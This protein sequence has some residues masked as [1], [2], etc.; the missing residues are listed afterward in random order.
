[1]LV[2]PFIGVEIVRYKSKEIDEEGGGVL[3][4]RIEN[5]TKNTLNTSLGAHITSDYDA[6]R[7]RGDIAWQHCFD[8]LKCNMEN[9]FLAFGSPFFV[10]GINQDQDG[11]WGVFNLS[12][13]T[14]DIFNLYAEFIG[15]WWPQWCAYGF[16]FGCD[17]RF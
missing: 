13:N 15:E 16:D 11:V 5:K 3:N 8:P 1:M 17:V 4:L 14:S 12:T 9:Q 2:Q 7:F 10:K 6:I